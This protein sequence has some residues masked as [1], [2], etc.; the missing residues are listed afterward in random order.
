GG[1]NSATGVTINGSNFEQ[2]AEVYLFPGGPYI[3][4]SVDLGYY[5]GGVYVSGS[6][7]YVANGAVSGLYV[8]D[9]SIPSSPEIIGFVDTPSRAK[10][11]Y[12]SGSYAYVADGGSGLQV[13][14]ISNPSHPVIIGS[15]DTPGEGYVVYGVYISGSHAYVVGYNYH[16]TVIPPYETTDDG[17]LQ[18]IDISTPS[19][20]TI[21]DSVAIRG[22]AYNFYV[23]GSYAYVVGNVPFGI[24]GARGFWV[25]DISTPSSLTIIGSIVV[26]SYPGPADIYVSGSYAYMVGVDRTYLY[27]GFLHVIDISI[28]SSP[29]IIGSVGTDWGTAVYVSD[30]YAYVT[31]HI[32]VPGYGPNQRAG[33]QVIDI[34]I[35]YSPAIIS[36]VKINPDGTFYTGGVYVS[37]SYAY[38]SDGSSGLKVIDISIPPRPSIDPV[39]LDSNVGNSTTITAAIP[40]D[41]PEG[42][43]HI[44]VSNSDREVGVL[45]NGFMILDGIVDN[46]D[47]DF[48][49]QGIW[50]IRPD[51]VVP[52]VYGKSFHYSA[53]GD[54]SDI[55][56]WDAKLV[57]G[58]GNYEVFVW[59]PVYSGLASNAPFTINHADISDTLVVDQGINGGQWMSLGIYEFVNDGTENITLSDKA[60][61]WVV[62]DAVK[63]EPTDLPPST[64]PTLPP[65]DGIIDNTDEGFRVEGRWPSSTRA[66]NFF[67]EDFQYHAAGDGSDT[68]AWRPELVNGAGSYEIFVWYPVYSGLATDAE[69]IINHANGSDRIL[70]DQSINGASWISLGVY[71]FTNKCGEG[72]T[73]TDNANSWVAADAVRFAP[74]DGIVDNADYGFSLVGVWKRY[75]AAP[76]ISGYGKDLRYH[77]PGDATDTAAWE[78][79]LVD[80]AGFYEVFIWYPVSSHLATNAP[81]TINHAG[82]SYTVRVDQ[83]VNGGHW[84]SLGIFEFDGTSSENV[85]MSADVD[86]RSAWVAAD[87]VRFSP[88]DM[89]KEAIIERMKSELQLICLS[90]EAYFGEFNTYS[91]DIEEIGVDSRQWNKYWEILI[92]ADEN[93][94]VVTATGIAYPVEG[95]ILSISGGIDESC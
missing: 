72:I 10:D 67:G 38:V 79:E 69:Y 40:A 91:D 28:P 57:S 88:A 76:G 7:A 82:G 15:V 39:L 49:V 26:D 58:A 94:F 50:G 35:P 47:P 34:S 86:Y 71:E 42:V 83:S 81:Y 78:A 33:L 30:S 64:P 31:G 18:V 68:A 89:S 70:I 36:S 53:P 22:E 92:E 73:L 11:V 19:S 84:V 46:S 61:T 51:N 6:Y 60:D 14:D 13:I 56:T 43:Y 44:R 62:A 21:I 65:S 12:V 25:I 77:A 1:N 55:A 75:N 52:G 32:S 80:G 66:P 87:A 3:K 85:T 4:G 59:Y 2:D 41:L 9:I 48:S 95:E 29:A 27:S 90:E 45:R 5:T 24:E 74:P 37:G 54:G 8:I 93:G 23:S 17:F 20:P 63:F 16:A